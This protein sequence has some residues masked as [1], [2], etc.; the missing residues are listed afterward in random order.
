[1]DM[2]PPSDDELNDLPHVVLTSDIDWDPSIVDN[3]M[4]LEEW[5]DAQMEHDD[6]P[7][8]NNYGD[9]TFDD[10]GYYREVTVNNVNFYNTYQYVSEFCELEDIVDHKI[11]VSRKSA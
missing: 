5:L 7:G 2:H 6:L 3:D 11:Q 10:Q 8:I 1:M 4:D 9:L